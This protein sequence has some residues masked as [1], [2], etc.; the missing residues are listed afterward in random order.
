MTQNI[1]DS[2]SPTVFSHTHK[3]TTDKVI[4][5]MTGWFILLFIKW[6]WII[7]KVFILIIF[8]LSRLWKR[9]SRTGPAVSGVAEMEEMEEVQ[10]EAGEAY[11]V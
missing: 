4:N 5:C 1:S 11:S 7:I 2:S 10:G 3:Y 8:M 6:K 9:K